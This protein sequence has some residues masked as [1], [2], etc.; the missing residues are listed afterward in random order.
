MADQFDDRF[1]SPRAVDLAKRMAV[2]KRRKNDIPEGYELGRDADG[3]VILVP[4]TPDTAPAR[5][6]FSRISEGAMEGYGYQPLG[7]SEKDIAEYPNAA[8]YLNPVAKAL[9]AIR[10]APGALAGAAAGTAGAGTEFLTGDRARANEAERATRSALEYFG[11]QG[12]ATMGGPRPSA[13]IPKNGELFPPE[14]ATT[15]QL[16]FTEKPIVDILR[17]LPPGVIRAG[18]AE[19]LPRLTY[20]EP[21][22]RY[23]LSSQQGQRIGP[24]RPSEAF[25]PVI[26]E[27]YTVP[28]QLNRTPETTA[29]SSVARLGD[30]SPMQAERAGVNRAAYEE[31]LADL[32]AADDAR[33]TNEGMREPG[34]RSPAVPVEAPPARPMT[35]PFSPAGEIRSPLLEMQAPGVKRRLT[36]PA[37][38]TPP[39]FDFGGPQSVGGQMVDPLTGRAYMPR[40]FDQAAPQPTAGSFSPFMRAEALVPEPVNLDAMLGRP[41][42]VQ[43]NVQNAIDIAKQRSD[44]MART[45]A[46]ASNQQAAIDAAALQVKGERARGPY[47][48]S[49]SANNLIDDAI[50]DATGDVSR[51]SAM[52]RA[53]QRLA[54]QSAAEEAPA[55]ARPAAAGEAPAAAAPAGN[56]L[57]A[58][59]IA[60]LRRNGFNEL[61]DQVEAV[62]AQQAASV[63]PAPAPAAAAPAAATPPASRGISPITG[64]LG[65]G[66]VGAGG[67]AV[68]TA[69]RNERRLQKALAAAQSSQRIDDMD[70]A[71]FRAARNASQPFQ[72]GT[73]SILPANLAV[74]PNFD[75]PAAMPP[76]SR[77][78]QN[79]P[80]GSAPA[81]RSPPAQ[82]PAAPAGGG[83]FLDKIFSGKDYQSSGGQLQ[84]Q[85]G[86]NRV[87]NWGDSDNAADFFRADAMRKR[88]EDQQQQFTGRSGSDLDYES[89][90][91][92]G[93]GESEGKAR[94]GAAEQKP[95]KEAMLHKSLEIIHHM[96][97][98][99]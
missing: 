97:K 85:Q 21:L 24:R 95:S 88:M 56:T 20:E 35:A 60:E 3:N 84:Q 79:Q 89:R 41:P 94:G 65:A 66:T 34:I 31:F 87:L 16:G 82:M 76:A 29:P 4:I 40:Q 72:T 64:L 14:P 77:P 44:A 63:A 9:D 36:R 68:A 73:S 75:V 99:R 10:R 61:A 33:A 59:D 46:D 27:M 80:T 92:A 69:D 70:E 55:V 1:S 91:R 48:R 26:D 50:A 96:I 45:A 17:E 67:L 13:K 98:N 71:A 81:T 86:G 90:M 49:Q 18:S 52:D 19:G 32:R 57:S 15:R 38:P 42:T 6:P 25:R 47:Q 7:M 8:R 93:Q 28:E 43:A 54:A 53:K 11:N 2:P 51:Q 22:T 5:S 83:S 58:A 30:E 12:M 74:D 23:G 39:T 37:E 62:Q 78:V